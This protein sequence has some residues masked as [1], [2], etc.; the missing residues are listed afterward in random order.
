VA[1]SIGRAP[2]PQTKRYV[3]V[4]AGRR[5]R[6]WVR[7]EF[8]NADKRS[9]L[10]SSPN[11]A[12]IPYM[13]FSG[14]KGKSYPHLLNLMP[15]HRTYIESH[16]GGG[17]V[18]RHKRAAQRQIGIDIDPAVIARWQNMPQ[19]PC[20]IVCADAVQYLDEIE[21]DAQT[22][23]YADPP[24]VR[25]TRK[26][27]RVYRFDY[28]DADHKRLIECLHS[29]SCMVMLSGYDNEMY[30]SALSGWDRIV[31]QA[32]THTG[33]REESVWINFDAPAQL[34]DSS[35]F[36]RNFREREVIKRRQFRLQSRIESLSPIEQHS[37]F[38]WLRQQLEDPL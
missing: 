9:L 35:Y 33:V 10:T 11:M 26:R 20:E 15:P 32:K 31:F 22:L 36:G 19:R 24:Y 17:A 5:K 28:T 3:G 14:G 23:I 1:I 34:H 21:V 37:L 16:L 18:M 12:M 6:F 2:P 8:F 13:H 29:K 30:R 38:T 4:R 25:T 7:E 27:S